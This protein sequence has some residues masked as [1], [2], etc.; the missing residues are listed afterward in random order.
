MRVLGWASSSEACRT[1]RR[2]PGSRGKT[3]Q[4]LGLGLRD[5]LSHLV[6]SGLPGI[7]GRSLEGSLSSGDSAR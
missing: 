4:E 1:R 2:S 7:R 6:L 3:P 5:L